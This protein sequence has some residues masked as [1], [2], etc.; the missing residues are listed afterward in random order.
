MKQK[1]RFR[2]LSSGCSYTV[3]VLCEL[4]HLDVIVIPDDRTNSEIAPKSSH[5]VSHKVESRDQSQTIVDF[6]V[7][8]KRINVKIF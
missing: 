5:K 1:T 3:Y 8:G 6:S 2:S 4:S 7:K